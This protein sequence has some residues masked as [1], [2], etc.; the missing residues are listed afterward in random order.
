MRATSLGS[1]DWNGTGG[2]A[3]NFRH[4]HTHTHTNTHTHTHTHAHTR[5]HR[6]FSLLLLL[7]LLLLPFALLFFFFFFF[8]FV[9]SSFVRFLF[10]VGF[11][12][13]LSVWRLRWIFRFVL[14]FVFL[15]SKPVVTSSFGTNGGERERERDKKQKHIGTNLFI[16][17]GFIIEG[18]IRWHVD[19]TPPLFLSLHGCHGNRIFFSSSSD[20][21]GML[22]TADDSVDCDL[23][24]KEGNAFPFAALAFRRV[25]QRILEH[26]DEFPDWNRPNRCRISELNERISWRTSGNVFKKSQGRPSSRTFQ[27]SLVIFVFICLFF[28]SCLTLGLLL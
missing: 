18:A 6:C 17:R 4:S 15:F 8:L 11:G 19:R 13:A 1:D 10:S 12:V 7:L 2:A 9:V 26:A 24:R 16:R 25:G 22:S 23:K 5:T 3:F 27:T 21:R 28:F 20:H 14:F